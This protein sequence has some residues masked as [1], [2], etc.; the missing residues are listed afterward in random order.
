MSAKRRDR[1][2]SPAAASP[3][4]WLAGIERRVVPALVTALAVAAPLIPT[5]SVARGTTVIL[6]LLALLGL[7][8]WAFGE[9]RSR[10]GRFVGSRIDLLLAAFL[11]WFTWSAARMGSA[12]QARLSI[13][14]T[15][16]WIGCGILWLL[17]RQTIRSPQAIRALVAVQVGLAVGL[18]TYGFYQCAYVMPQDRVAFQQD[19]DAVLRAAGVVA[20]VGSPLRAQ[21]ANRLE[22]REPLATFAL[23]NSLAGYLLP[24][25]VVSG[26]MLVSLA[27]TSTTRRIW[28]TWLSAAIV[29]TACVLLTK[30]RS[31]YVA[32]AAAAVVV[33]LVALRSDL[34][35]G[36]K[37]PLALAGGLALMVALAAGTGYLDVEVFSEARKSLGYRWEYW[38][39]TLAMLRDYPLTGCGPGNFQTFYAGYK[40]PQS[41]EM[42]ADPHNFALEIA[43][44]AGWPALLIWLAACGGW[45]VAMLRRPVSSVTDSAAK[46][47]PSEGR[48]ASPSTGAEWNGSTAVHPAAGSATKPILAGAAMGL[49]LGWLVAMVGGFPLSTAFL[50]VAIPPAVAI[51]VGLL[52]WLDD[53][54]LPRPWLASG[55]GALLVSLLAAGGIGFPAVALGWWLLAALALN[56]TEGN[57]PPRPAPRWLWG[58][59]G[60]SGLLLLGIFYATC[61]RPVFSGATQMAFGEAAVQRGD[62]EEALARYEAAAADDPWTAEPWRSLAGIRQR[63]WLATGNVRAREAFEEAVLEAVRRDPRS[64]GRRH[65]LAALFLQAYREADDRAALADAVALCRDAVALYPNHSLGRAQ[66][67]WVLHLAG[68]DQGSR[69]EAARALALDERNPHREQKL[70]RQTLTDFPTGKAASR[71]VS[72]GP[73]GSNARECLERIVQGDRE[74]R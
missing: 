22:S 14:V 48:P 30:S 46:S 28:W 34:R 19:P 57:A 44:T 47:V 21:Y 33:A 15:W 40:L 37:L 61:Y 56:L 36:W 63:I 9:W 64:Q 68:D 10:A 72:T 6:Q 54:P 5:E 39:A 62:Y 52:P 32:G 4:N 66:L 3:S 31:A 41:S 67:A 18:S 23:T 70:D 7:A 26:G 45:F 71:Q 73:E 55:V 2:P 17:T 16:A 35:L 74:S 58:I 43:A 50:F 49:A 25:L 13:N 69:A 24:W 38:Q 60:A 20:P 12:G 1:T 29:L 11:L 42:V 27:R 65:E 53:G 59:V 51:V 8:T